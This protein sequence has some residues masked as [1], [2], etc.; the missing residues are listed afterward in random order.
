MLL[1]HGCLVKRIVT[2]SIPLSHRIQRVQASAH[3][4]GLHRCPPL[5]KFLASPSPEA[6]EPLSS[7]SQKEQAF[8]REI[9]FAGVDW[10]SNQ[11]ATCAVYI[12]T[13]PQ[14]PTNQ[15]AKI[16]P[17]PN[18][19]PKKI[20]PGQEHP[21]AWRKPVLL[22]QRLKPVA[23]QLRAKC[24][25]SCTKLIPCFSV[26]FFSFSFI[27]FKCSFVNHSC[28]IPKKRENKSAVLHKAERFSK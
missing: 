14:N 19:R 16:K 26:F 3:P 13:G 15:K 24:A 28:Q 4:W 20:H 23:L 11:A 25:T 8:K 12:H 1:G 17:K 10:S 18:K 21:L 27:L 2:L 6:S 22:G 7:S 9:N 5:R